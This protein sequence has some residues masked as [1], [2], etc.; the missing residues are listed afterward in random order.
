MKYYFFYGGIRSSSP[1]ARMMASRL[2]NININTSAIFPSNQCQHRPFWYSYSSYTIT[3]DYWKKAA[4][5]TINYGPLL[6]KIGSGALPSIEIK[7]K[8]PTQPTKVPFEPITAA[9]VPSPVTV[10]NKEPL[11]EPQQTEVIAAGRNKWLQ[12]PKLK[13]SRNSRGRSSV[14][15]GELRDSDM[16]GFATVG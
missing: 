11:D 5:K 9:M 7:E 8:P 12:P 15:N 16:D 10:A 1:A 3:E 2:T 13:S 14:A 6:I 4:S